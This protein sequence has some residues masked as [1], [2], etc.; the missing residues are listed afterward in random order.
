MNMEI[1]F[2]DEKDAE[3]FLNLCKIIAKVIEKNERFKSQ[4][5]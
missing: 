2:K 3:T 1:Y 5:F 4:K